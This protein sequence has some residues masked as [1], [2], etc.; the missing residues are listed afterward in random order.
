MIAL[1]ILMNEFIVKFKNSSMER[2][3][4]EKCDVFRSLVIVSRLLFIVSR[5]LLIVSRL[6]FIVS[7]L[8]FIVSRLL[9]I[10]SRSLFI[11]SCEK[12]KNEVTIKVTGTQ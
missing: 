8:L 1:T 6:L 7:R 4:R 12:E 2:R 3:N 9:F 10:V 11:V 5:L